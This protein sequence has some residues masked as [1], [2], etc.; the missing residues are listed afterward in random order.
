MDMSGFA[1]TLYVCCAG[2]C[3]PTIV[4]SSAFGVVSLI[5]KIRA[6]LGLTKGKLTIILVSIFIVTFILTWALALFLTKDFYVM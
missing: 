4:T 3:I 6:G 5:P 2:I 1:V